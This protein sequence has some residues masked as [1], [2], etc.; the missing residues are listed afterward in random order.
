MF[1]TWGFAFI[2][3]T[4]LIKK[5]TT[6]FLIRVVALCGAVTFTMLSFLELDSRMIWISCIAVPVGIMWSFYAVAQNISLTKLGKGKDFESYFSLS[7]IIGQIVSIVNPLLFAGVISIIG[8]NGSFLLMFVFVALLMVVSFYIP[9]ISL[10]DE[11]REEE[12]KKI[13]S[14]RPIQWIMLSC[15]IAGFF[16]QF[17]GI[18]RTCIYIFH[19]RKQTSYCAIKHCLYTIYYRGDNFVPKEESS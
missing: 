5:W 4:Q 3:G 12:I 18:I 2:F 9:A 13:L 6:R 7:S 1:T 16:L 15:M 10:K 19:F 11:K 14:I 17:Q 8:F